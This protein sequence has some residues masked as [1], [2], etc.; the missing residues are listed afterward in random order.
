MYV[1]AVV[2]S[3]SHTNH[4]QTTLVFTEL[5]V[6]GLVD[7][8]I[9]GLSDSHYSCEH[10]APSV[11]AVES[12]GGGDG[13]DTE[14]DGCGEGH[15]SDVSAGNVLLECLHERGH[16][17]RHEPGCERGRGGNIH[18]FLLGLMVKVASGMMPKATM[19]AVSSGTAGRGK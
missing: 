13:Y 18:R 9:H 10:D 12:A 5:A 16:D 4:C 19:V 1:Y 17:Q 8:R 6:E 7:E 3:C 2:R 15:E 11:G 14:Q